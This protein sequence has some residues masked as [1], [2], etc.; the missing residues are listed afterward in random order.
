MISL[1]VFVHTK[2]TLPMQLQ[3]DGQNGKYVDRNEYVLVLPDTYF[4]LY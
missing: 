2:A 4:S 3:T 1:E